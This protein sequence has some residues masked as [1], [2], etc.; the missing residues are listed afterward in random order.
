MS[1]FGTADR[2]DEPRR[3]VDDHGHLGQS[4]RPGGYRR[5]RFD[6][7][8]AE[9]QVLVNPLVAAGYPSIGCVGKSVGQGAAMTASP[10]PPLPSEPEPSESDTAL[11]SLGGM[12]MPSA[13]HTR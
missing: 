6:Q 1:A 10:V 3:R 9:H 2:R 5:T 12:G 4:A 8:V 7:Y 13:R 11:T